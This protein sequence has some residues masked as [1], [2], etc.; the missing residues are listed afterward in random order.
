MTPTERKVMEHLR[1]AWNQFTQLPQSH[2]DDMQ[3]FRFSIHRLQDL[4]GRRVAQRD[5][6]E[7]WE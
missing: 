1:E 6:P 3:E 7:E 2:S 5:Y 4:I